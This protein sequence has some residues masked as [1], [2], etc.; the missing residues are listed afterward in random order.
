MSARSRGQVAG[1]LPHCDGTETTLRPEGSR[2]TPPGDLRRARFLHG[3]AGLFSHRSAHDSKAPLRAI[4]PVLAEDNPRRAAEEIIFGRLSTRAARRPRQGGEHRAQHGHALRHGRVARP[5][6]ARIGVGGFPRRCRSS[7]RGPRA[8]RRRAESGRRRGRRQV[9][10][11]VNHRQAPYA[12]GA[13]TARSRG[14]RAALAACDE[15]DFAAAD[16]SD[17]HG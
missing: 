12:L 11:G 9:A 8:R 5:P 4:P 13:H 6:R 17:R 7:P 3:E 16:F 10:V 1:T 15:H 14:L 2:T